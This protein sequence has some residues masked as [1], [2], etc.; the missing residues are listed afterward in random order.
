MPYP[1]NYLRSVGRAQCIEQGS[2][3]IR[4]L[5]CRASQLKLVNV[6]MPQ[7][8]NLQ[9]YYGSF[10]L[11]KPDFSPDSVFFSEFELGIG[12]SA[13]LKETEV[14]SKQGT[15]FSTVLEINLQ[16]D[17]PEKRWAIDKLVGE[18]LI[19][20]L[21]QDD[22]WVRILMNYNHPLDVHQER[23]GMMLESSYQVGNGNNEWTLSFKKQSRRRDYYMT[24]EQFWDNSIWFEVNP[25]FTQQYTNFFYE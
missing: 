2:K 7:T 18:D 20:F 13:K 23:R 1:Y 21:V 10:N 16:N 19:F 6:G 4:V 14:I 22:N 15:L 3:I 12:D 8:G 17:F 25:P 5:Y 9:P 11:F 24:M